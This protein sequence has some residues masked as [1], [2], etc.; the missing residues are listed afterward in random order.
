MTES[1]KPASPP[2]QAINKADDFPSGNDLPAPARRDV[3][4]S[5][6]TFSPPKQAAEAGREWTGSLWRD[7]FG[8]YEYHVPALDG[9]PSP[10][11]FVKKSAF[12]KVVEERDKVADEAARHWESFTKAEEERD[13]ARAEVERLRTAISTFFTSHQG[14]EGMSDAY[15]G[16][17]ASLEGSKP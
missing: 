7:R 3:A 16:L 15:K 14:L 5:S 9:D 12:Q 2:K 10:M 1:D 8:A 17:R 6:G 13:E 11:H 4:E